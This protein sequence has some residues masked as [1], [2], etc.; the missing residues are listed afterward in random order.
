MVFKVILGQI[1]VI[2]F[3]IRTHDPKQ[4]SATCFLLAL[5]VT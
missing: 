4:S 2:T 1:K 5:W 3:L